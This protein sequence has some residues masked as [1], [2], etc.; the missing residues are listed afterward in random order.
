VRG[1]FPSLPAGSVGARVAFAEAEVVDD[2]G[3]VIARASSSYLFTP[4]E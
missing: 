2:A 1:V 4:L 3:V